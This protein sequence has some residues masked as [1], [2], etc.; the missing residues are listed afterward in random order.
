MSIAGDLKLNGYPKN[1]TVL[2]AQNESDKNY[3]TPLYNFTAIPFPS[4]TI[5]KT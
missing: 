4:T 2:Y 5:D 1:T 3:P